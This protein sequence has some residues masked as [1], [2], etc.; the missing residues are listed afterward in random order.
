MAGTV[1]LIPVNATAWAVAGELGF[2]TVGRFW[3]QCQSALAGLARG[4]RI[5]VSLTGVT[6]SDSAGLAL[7]VCWLGEAGAAGVELRYEQV[8]ARLLGLARISEVDRLLQPE[9]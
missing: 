7:L 8:P 5:T 6:R 1:Q 4:S 9:D 3:P 2:P